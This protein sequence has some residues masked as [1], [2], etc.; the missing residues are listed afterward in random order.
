MILAGHFGR[1]KEILCS[2][3]S[4]YAVADPGRVWWVSYEVSQPTPLH[5]ARSM[6]PCSAAFECEQFIDG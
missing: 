4:V 1:T 6:I 3:R 5:S 2:K